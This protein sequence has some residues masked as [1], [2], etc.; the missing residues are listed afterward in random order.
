ME[1]VEFVIGHRVQLFLDDWDRYEMSG[2]I[3]QK[4]TVLESGKV[5]NDGGIIQSELEKKCS[6][7]KRLV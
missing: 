5:G 6:N 3:K 2:R 7:I 4:T 1:N